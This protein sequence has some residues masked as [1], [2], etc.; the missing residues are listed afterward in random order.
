MLKF[1]PDSTKILLS[2]NIQSD[3]VVDGPGI[4]TVIWTQGC[5]HNCDQCHNPETHSFNSGYLTDIESVCK[6]ILFYNQN[7]T[8]SGGDPMLQPAQCA[9]IAKFAKKMGLTIW[10]YTGFKFDDLISFNDNDINNFLANIDVLVDGKFD[11]KQK[12]FEC[13]YRGSTNQR[14]IDVKSSLE[15]N[16]VIEWTDPYQ[17]LEN[18]KNNDLF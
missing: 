5:I 9:T 3:S 12:S 2:S 6:K 4:R 11:I 13:Q 15:Y 14:L 8:F 1:N 10:V 17:K 16:K 7:I 18:Q